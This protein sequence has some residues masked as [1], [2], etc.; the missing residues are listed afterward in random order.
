MEDLFQP[1]VTAACQ[2][3]RGRPAHGIRKA[4]KGRPR[5]PRRSTVDFGFNEEQEMLRQ[6]ARALLEKECPS[7]V[8]RKLMDDERGFDPALWKKMA[9][10]GW[11]GLVIPEEY[12]GGGLSYVDL[13]LIMEEMGRVGLP[14][15]FIWTVMVA[16]ALKRAGSD[17]HKSSL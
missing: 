4:H 11:L 8:V 6:S 1:S 5:K 10:L 16:E 3:C 14:S 12:G 2:T 9:E 13:V 7:T 15:P 17:H